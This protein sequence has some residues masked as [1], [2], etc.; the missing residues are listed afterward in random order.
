MLATLRNIVKRELGERMFDIYLVTN[1]GN[2]KY[3]VTMESS[4]FR[5][6]HSSENNLMLLW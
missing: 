6:F 5:M 3:L 4:F 1:E 2:L